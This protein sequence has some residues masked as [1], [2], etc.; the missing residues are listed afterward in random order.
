MRKKMER[1]AENI[2][3]LNS[4]HPFRKQLQQELTKIQS[5]INRYWIVLTD[6]GMILQTVQLLQMLLELLPGWMGVD[7]SRLRRASLEGQPS[8]LIH[9]LPELLIS[10]VS[11][12]HMT[13]VR[14]KQNYLGMVRE[15]HIRQIL[16]LTC[17]LLSEQ[18]II[19]NPYLSA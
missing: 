1:Q 14:L 4:T 13:M 3:K 8:E 10:L 7:Y 17:L 19:T 2:Q 15:E 16:E 11:K 12:Y 9:F 6:D 5:K 18:D